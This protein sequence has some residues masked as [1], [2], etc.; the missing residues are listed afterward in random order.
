VEQ[1]RTALVTGGSRG[2]GRAISQRL[3]KDGF[4][5]IV[6]Y[7]ANETEARSTVSLIND[8]GGSA[9]ICPFDVTDRAAVSAA[10]KEIVARRSLQVAVLCAGVRSDEALVFMNDEQWDRVLAVNLDGFYSVAKPVAAHMLLNREGRI[11]AISS[12]SGESGLAGQV[13]YSAAKAGLIGAVKSLA[14]ECAKRGVLVN[15]ITPG[16]IETDLLEG[17]DLKETAARIPMKRLGR[18]DEVA[19]AAA[20]LASPDSSYITG[21]VIRVNGGVYL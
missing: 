5:V 4:H 8:G 16:F 7:H 2:I 21:Q 17:M 6:N 14:L 15:A 9:E 20:F 1:K 12:T 11:I 13:N 10:I 18:P 3:A 19:A